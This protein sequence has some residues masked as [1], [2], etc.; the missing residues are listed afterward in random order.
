MTEQEVIIV[1]GIP[2]KEYAA[3]VEQSVR[4][5]LISLPFTSDR[6][7]IVD[8]KARALNIAK[9]KVAE[10]LFRYFCECNSIELDFEACATPFWRIDHRDFVL[11]DDEWDIKNN[12]IYHRGNCYDRYTQL[13]ALI[14][15]RFRGDQ[16]T[17]RKT[18]EIFYSLQIKY[19]FTFLKNADLT[20]GERGADFLQLHLS[21]GQ[22]EFLKELHAR[23]K[24]EVQRRQPFTEAWFW[25]K[26][27]QLG[28]QPLYTLR[29]QPQLIITAYA[30]GS[31]FGKFQDT[32]GGC[33]AFYYK[34]YCKPDWYKVCKNGT[35]DFMAGTMMTR[36]K[37][38][39]CPIAELPS[40]YS[41][42][43]HLKEG[44]QGAVLKKV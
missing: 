18:H 40:F 33:T 35:I 29:S 23:Y 4:Y 7:N 15:N 13:P 6:I 31:T 5:A 39:T 20:K 34:D 42:F 16:W 38:A 22:E 10:Q 21:P 11:G 41:L 44:M 2:E 1:N 28:S 37:N 36:I 32:G 24:G 9:G 30:D 43:P 17:K 19:L 27:H 25:E 26:M 3:L 8:L 14:P 12:F